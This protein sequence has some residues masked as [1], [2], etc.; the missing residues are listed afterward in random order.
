MRNIYL[1]NEKCVAAS[2]DTRNWVY[3]DMYMLDINRSIRHNAERHDITYKYKKNP[4]LTI[5]KSVPFVYVHMRRIRY[6]MDTAIKQSYKEMM[7]VL[8]WV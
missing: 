5:P 2:D 6:N 7:E 3:V 8:L 4:P 1:H